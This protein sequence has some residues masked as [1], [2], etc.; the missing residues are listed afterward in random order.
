MKKNNLIEYETIERYLIFIVIIGVY[1]K[2]IRMDDIHAYGSCCIV[3][4]SYILLSS[5]RDFLK[6]GILKQIV[7]I[8]T[9]AATFSLGIYHFLQ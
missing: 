7:T 1:F 5:Y 3:T 9:C 8:A 4:G 6:Y 2:T